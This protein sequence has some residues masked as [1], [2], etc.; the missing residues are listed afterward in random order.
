MEQEKKQ[1]LAFKLN[2][3][4]RQI[5]QLQ[6]QMEAVENGINDLGSINFGLDELKGGIGKEI[7][8]P[9]GKGIFVKTKLASE[10]LTVDIGGRNFVKK[11]IPETKKIIEEQVKKLISIRKDI[12]ESLEKISEEMGKSLKEFQGLK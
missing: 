5:H 9:V 4:E 12:N 10:D 8:S 3:F 6:E 1:E 11:S 2:M 7:L